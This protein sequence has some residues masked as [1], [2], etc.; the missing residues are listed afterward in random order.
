M[1]RRKRADLKPHICVT[2]QLIR[3]LRLLDYRTF[4]K[5]YGFTKVDYK[6]KANNTCRVLVAPSRNRE[7]NQQYKF[8]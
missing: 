8:M 6:N 2:A 7:V 5:R 3:D 4:R 1:R